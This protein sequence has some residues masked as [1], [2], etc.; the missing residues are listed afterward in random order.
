MVKQ[1]IDNFKNIDRKISK[2]MKYGLAFC[3]ILS[4]LA[5]SLLIT[6]LSFSA[7]LLLFD[8]GIILFKFSLTLAVEFIICGYAVDIIF[9]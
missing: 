9:R 5:C 3:F 4:I 2:I 8:I 6:Y 7:N 1:F